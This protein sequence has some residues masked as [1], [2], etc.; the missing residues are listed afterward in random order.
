MIELVSSQVNKF[1]DDFTD[2]CVQANWIQRKV[3]PET[4]AISTIERVKLTKSDHLQKAVE[5]IDSINAV[6]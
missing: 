5:S 3:A 4:V 1:E 2:I 6:V